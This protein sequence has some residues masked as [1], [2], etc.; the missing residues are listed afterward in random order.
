MRTLNI[1]RWGL[2]FRKKGLRP[3]A[4]PL[5]LNI[6]AIGAECSRVLPPVHLTRNY[7]LESYD[8]EQY[9]SGRHSKLLEEVVECFGE[10]FQAGWG[11]RLLR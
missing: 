9:E 2:S 10:V 7:N 5:L 3:S 11:V 4:G 1:F 6:G 8:Y